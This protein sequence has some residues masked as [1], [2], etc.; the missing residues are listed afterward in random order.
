[1]LAFCA[2]IFSPFRLRIVSV[3]CAVKVNRARNWQR[4]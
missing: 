2:S 4:N 1:M 3:D